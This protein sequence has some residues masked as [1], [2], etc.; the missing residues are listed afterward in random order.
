[1]QGNS[2]ERVSYNY[3]SETTIEGLPPTFYRKARY[4][5]KFQTVASITKF[6]QDI[7]KLFQQ[8]G[9][10]VCPQCKTGEITAKYSHNVAHEISEQNNK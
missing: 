3:F 5:L 6:D 4:F 9:K 10:R 7:A 2:K 8:F 1:M